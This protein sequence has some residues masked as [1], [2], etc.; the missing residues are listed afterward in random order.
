MKTKQEQLAEMM[1]RVEHDCQFCVGHLRD[2]LH[3][4]GVVQGSVVLDLIGRAAELERLV[5][6]FGEAVQSDLKGAEHVK[7]D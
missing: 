5:R 6:Q 1:V 3:L 2:A 4:S 7:A